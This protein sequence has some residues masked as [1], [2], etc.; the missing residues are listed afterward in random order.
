MVRPLTT[1]LIRAWGDV[2]EGPAPTVPAQFQSGDWSVADAGTGGTIII[3]ITSLP[4][5]GG[6]PITALEYSID[7]GAFV[8]LGGISTGDYPVS[9]LV[10]DVMVGVILRA[11]NAVGA[12]PNSTNK[13]VTPTSPVVSAPSVVQTK[14]AAD[15]SVNTSCTF[16]LPAT[17]TVG[18]R[19]YIVLKTGAAV[20]FSAVPAGWELAFEEISI[21]TGFRVYKKTN[22]FAGT[23]GGTTL[24]WTASG[25][26]TACFAF[27]EAAD[28]VGQVDAVYIA[29]L[30]P[31]AV[32]PTGGA[33]DTIILAV[34]AIR[35]T[36]NDCTAPP[37]N[38]TANAPLLVE[39]AAASTS[40]GHVALAAAHREL[41][42]AAE[43]PGT[44]TWT[45]TLTT[46][47][48]SVTVAIR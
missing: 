35:R 16:V 20:T 23:E 5:D 19:G 6:S 32:A 34:S 39:T 40:S 28:S 21:S 33:T 9:G 17:I 12:G 11:V 48:S 30:N 4:A 22:P 8:A 2:G 47:P 38:Y 1:P 27:L 7:G 29:S 43:D 14:N 3:S 41:S 36:D 25:A 15:T 45:G 44:F 26:T 37:A 10:N 18:T 46:D 24:T 31:P 13:A 42:T